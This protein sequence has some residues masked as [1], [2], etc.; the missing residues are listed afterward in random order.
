MMGEEPR[1]PSEDPFILQRE[2][3]AR[4]REEGP[5]EV[6]K[7]FSELFGGEA[8][9]YEEYEKRLAKRLKE[10]WGWGDGSD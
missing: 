5:R 1:K 4:M 6:W 3:K 2:L 9:S 8:E 10:Q 7:M